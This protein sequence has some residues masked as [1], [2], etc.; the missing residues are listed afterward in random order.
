MQMN[1][2]C[3]YFAVALLLIP[4]ALA[5]VIDQDTT[6][7][8]LPLH[9]K[10]VLPKDYDANK[11][12]P[13]VLAFPPGGQGMDMVMTTLVQNWAGEAQK[14]GYIVVIP[15]AP[16][17]H[18]FYEEGARVFPEFLNKLLSDYKIRDNK[19]HIAGM[20]NGGISAFYIAA[21]YP[22]FFSSVTGFPGYL[23]DAAPEQLKA[24][25]GLCVH[26]HVG[27]FDTAW[28]IAMQKQASDLRV[29]GINAHFSIENG[30]QH[31]IRALTGERAVR[32]FD[33][34]EHDCKPAKGTH[35]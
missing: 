25:S 16:N 14:R 23:R 32:L 17:G 33:E 18:V 5:K 10:V 13:A 12:Y 35:Q 11:A 15:A 34:I 27:E 22:S 19:F 6:I 30:E 29:A 2:A 7:T 20:S 21:S 1:L 31:V 28:R 3:K 24:L 9:Y 8:G 26:M 4:A